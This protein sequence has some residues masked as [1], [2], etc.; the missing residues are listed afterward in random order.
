MKK[1]LL[2]AS[3]IFLVRLLPANNPTWAQDVAPILYA[4]CTT[5]HHPGSIAPFSLLSYN[6]AYS[7]ASLINNDLTLGL[8]PPWP[9]DTTYTRFLHERILNSAQI[10][11]IKQWAT[12]GKAEGD[13]TQA[14]SQ[15]TYV[16]GSQL[17]TVS[18]SV[19][20]PTYTVSGTGDVY[21]NFPI[22]TGL[23]QDMYI[24]A[25]EV[26][27]GNAAIVH[28]VLVYQDSTN[29]PAQLDAND[30]GPGY[31]DAGGTGSN[32]SI[33]IN[34]WAPGA[35][36]YYTPV[37]TGFR[38]QANTNI[39]VQ[40]HYPN[41][42]Q[43]Q[44]D[45]TRVNFTLTPI[46]QRNISVDPILNYFTSMTNG[47]ISIPANT[48]KTYYEKYTVPINV[49]LLGIFPH[50]HLIGRSIKSWANRPSTNDTIPLI[51]IPNWNFHWQ[52]TYVFPNALEIPNGSSLQASAY[53]D[54]T[55][56]NP[57]NPNSPPQN[58]VAGTSTTDEMMLVYFSY[59]P[60]QNGDT[61]II[62][63]RRVIPQGATTFCSGQSVTLQ[64]II[65]LRYTYQWY[66]GSTSIAGATGSTYV[67]SQ[68]GNYYAKIV[69]G[70][71]STYTDTIAVSII[72]SSPT[73]SVLP[74]S[75][76]LCSGQ[77]AT[78][79]AT[80]GSNYIYQWFSDTI[81]IS[82]ATS[83]SYSATAAGNYSVQVYN[84]CYAKSAAVPVTVVSAPSA[85]VTPS[86]ATTFCQGNNVT[87]SAPSGL[88][89]NWSNGSTAQSIA[90]SQ[91]GNYTVTV[92]SGGNCT[93]VSTVTAVTVNATPTATVSAGGATSFCAGQNVILSATAN[94]SY[95][96]NN[97]ATAQNITVTQTG[98][99]IVTVT[100]AN[101]CTAASAPVQV[102]V[103]QLPTASITAGGATSFCSGG[104]VVLTA[105]SNA[106]YHWSN[107]AT[108]QTIT[109]TI[110]GTY[111]VTVTDA[112]SC[113]N[114]ATTNVTVYSLPDTAV[115]ANKPTTIC[116]GDNVTLTGAAGL[117]YNWSNGATTQS[118]NISTTGN[119]TLTVT[120]QHSCTA[121]SS[122][123]AV[124]VS[125]N[126]TAAITPSGPTSFCSG[127]S[128]VLTA[129]AGTNYNWSTGST[130]QSITVSASGSYTVSVTVSGS[131]TAVSNP[132]TV[133]IYQNPAAP[134]ITASGAISFCSGDSVSLSA[135]AGYSYLWSNTETAQQL[136]VTASGNYSVII[137]DGNSCTASSSAT[138]VTVN[139]LPVVS[140]VFTDSSV[141]SNAPAFVLTGGTPGGGVYWGS[142]VTSNNF[143]PAT[144][145]LGT[146]IITYTYT[147]NNSCSNNSTQ[148]I[149]IKSCLGLDDVS[150]QNIICI[151]NPSNGNFEVDWL[152][153]NVIVSEIAVYDLT[154][155]LIYTY[156]AGLSQKQSVS[157]LN[158]AS[159]CY[160]L[161]LKTEQGPVFRKLMIE[162]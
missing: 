144:A 25:V 116:P 92:S 35:S 125:N 3:V 36:P 128:V 10:N 132:Q 121:V 137:T 65:G 16:A 153:A 76:T 81:P 67:A 80:T 13:I 106:L 30:P 52:G 130:G 51:N 82:G 110:G 72:S 54:N 53:Y 59:M 129:S 4:H 45:S 64:T 88:S 134:V 162:R 145:G 14:P 143:S 33:L 74:I 57:N 12:G 70:P 139:P 147:D 149:T 124:T 29:A 31:T 136:N 7:H 119:F 15:P 133:L 122:P 47:P 117:N 11:L 158:I 127:N 86:G 138:T 18:L 160:I 97:N 34:G 78:L 111:V 24:T 148:N 150:L 61:N 28:H 151:P 159:S 115:T 48:T 77:S 37:G 154:G 113:S 146:H 22:P 17:G 103:H 90:V 9:P 118:V 135:P 102:T 79:N 107:N 95:R 56:N 26:I 27:P 84:G 49:T 109:A 6:D 41:G 123:I 112:N 66:N 23:S 8:M 156:Y 83:S 50:M 161:M 73:A 20:I 142:G 44:S 87:L 100:D 38:L 101:S 155:K 63:D 60:Y 120:D 98:S 108:T 58:V 46:A 39:V 1:S 152:G 42:T 96:W 93:A 157:L 62:V 104:S 75:A 94:L 43:G 89:Y 114:T 99:Y 69:L 105:A 5:C 141:C 40:V 131:C 2:L 126:A 140:L 19:Q 91:S 21:R 85:T 71:N 68:P 55:S 32:A